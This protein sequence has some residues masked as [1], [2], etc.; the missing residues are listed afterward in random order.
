MSDTIESVL[1]EQRVFSPSPE[2]KEQAHLKDMADYERMH[3]HS[4]SDPEGFWGEQAQRLIPW[5]K[6]IR[7]G[8][9]VEASVLEVV[10]RRAD[11]RLRRLRRSTPV[12]S[13]AQQSSHYLGR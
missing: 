6:P 4:I 10:H 11:Q 2:F 9:G 3:A 8:P 1:H 13:A 5:S 12:W 7:E